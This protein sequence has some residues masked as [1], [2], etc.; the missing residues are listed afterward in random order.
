[1]V[2]YGSIYGGIENL[3]NII[4]SKLADNGISNIAMYDVSS[5]HFSD[6]VSEAFK[7]SHIVIASSTYNAGIFTNMETVL[8][9]LKAHNLQN[10]TSAIAENGSWAPTSGG[11]MENIITSMK[12]M[13]I[14]DKKITIR[15]TVKE[16]QLD[17]INIMVNEIVRSIKTE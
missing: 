13:T 3:A 11:L 10:R 7:Y 6:I 12:N 17:D 5:T 14:I 4:A 15:S 1:M 2:I 9:D 8:L 16:H